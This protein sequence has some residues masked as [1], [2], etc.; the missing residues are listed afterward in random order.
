MLPHRLK[1]KSN[2][3]G[4]LS[5]HCLDRYVFLLCK[6]VIVNGHIT[7][8]KLRACADPEGEGAGV[9]TSLR[10]KNHKIKG[11]LSN[12]GE[13]PLKNHKATKP[14]FNVGPPLKWRFPG[15]P[16]MAC[17]YCY[18]NPLLLSPLIKNVVRVGPPL[19]RLFGSAHEGNRV[20]LLGLCVALQEEWQ[21]IPR[22]EICH[23]TFSMPNRWFTRL[24]HV[25]ATPNIDLD[26]ISSMCFW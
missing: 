4:I 25:E 6:H 5:S 21:H 14:A 17:F 23:N 16:M 26:S 8:L 7:E 18:L 22:A 12:T 11:F 15:G 1:I 9:R 19:A 3:I 10:L 20:F 2:I 13:D 24:S